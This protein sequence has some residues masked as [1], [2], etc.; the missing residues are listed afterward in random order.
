[1]SASRYRAALLL[2]CASTGA[3][4]VETNVAPHSTVLSTPYIGAPLRYLTD[5]RIGSP[6]D[7]TLML[8]A[9]LPVRTGHQMPVQ[10][11]FLFP[12]E[13]RVSRVRLFQHAGTQGRTPASQYVIELDTSGRGS[14]T[15]AVNEPNG[16]GGAWTTHSL[17]PAVRAHALRFRTLAY[18]KVSGPNYGGAVLGEIEIYTDDPVVVGTRPQPDR[19]APWLEEDRSRSRSLAA[20]TAA[21][22]DVGT[23]PFRRG[24]FGS[25]W[26]HWAAGSRYSE[27]DNAPKVALLQRLH[28]NRYWLYPNVYVAKSLDQ[29]FVTLPHDENYR[30]FI[31]R[32]ARAAGKEMR[33]LPFQSNV[34][35]GHRGNALRPLVAQMNR[36]GIRVI[37][38]QSLLPFGLQSWDYPRVMNPEVYPSVLTSAFA[39]DGS[40][41]LYREFMEA[42]VD[43]LALGG[44]EFF[45]HGDSGANGSAA[46]LCSDSSGKL[47]DICQ[48]TPRR[49]FLERFGIDYTPSPLAGFDANAARW[50]VFEYE[51]L[52]RLFARHARMMKEARPDAIVTALFRPGEEI[53]PAYRIAYD[54][55]GGMGAIDEMSSDPYWG[56]DSH[57]GHYYFA[58]ETKRLAAASP[59]QTAVVTLQTTPAFDR[60]GYREP[61]MVYGPALSALMHGVGGVNFYKIDY[62]FSGHADDPGPWVEKFFTLT[63]YLDGLGLANY[64]SPKTVAVV[65]SRSSEDWMLLANRSRPL[66]AAEATLY[67]G[68]VMEVLF[69]NAIPFDVYYLDRPDTL[70]RLS[71]YEAIVLP[72]PYSIASDAAERI[73][74]A[75]R[76]GTSVLAVARKGEVDEFGVPHR[77]PVLANVPGMHYAN[78]E[79]V[80]TNYDRFSEAMLDALRMASPGASA[81]GIDANGSDV[82]CAVREHGN[83]RLLFCVNW[84]GHGVDVE[85][86]LRVADGD[87]R[88]SVLTLESVSPA[89]IGGSAALKAAAVRRFRLALAPGEAKIVHVVAERAP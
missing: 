83:N 86:R 55:L 2:A 1:M 75:S 5:G 31:D 16:R 40:T 6:A 65:Y 24:V 89:T 79:L 78:I 53:R 12:H 19:K 76:Q 82:E 35:P 36:A 39:R 15:V 60:R 49:A 58:N 62:L 38:N 77:T 13:V 68:A 23:P 64:R 72:Y 32:Q 27:R 48:P 18:G 37:A 57:L 41:A 52:A 14:Y 8:A 50:T 61:I 9:P 88:A 46:P 84:E 54:I 11:E 80:A 56:N 28:V 70:D 21:A 25:M 67:Q 45:V 71:A 69:R 17:A 63:T 30:Y 66:A 74:A 73:R 42:G 33:I 22:A 26:M 3:A 59:T 85:V 4:G 47:R 7:G 51:Q 20:A 29:P 87:Y 81:F 10:Y 34:A 44:D 43:G